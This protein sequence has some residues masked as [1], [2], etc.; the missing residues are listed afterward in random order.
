MLV[1]D[2]DAD[3]RLFRRALHRTGIDCDLQWIANIATAREALARGG[4]DLY[5]IDYHLGACTGVALWADVSRRGGAGP[6]IL[7]SGSVGEVEDEARDAG[8]SAVLHKDELSSAVLAGAIHG[9]IA[10]SR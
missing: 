4:F 1:D 7:L 3:F 9:V 6:A 2:D 5:V 8:F 10:P